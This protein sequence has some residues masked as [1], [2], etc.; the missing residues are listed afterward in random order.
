VEGIGCHHCR[1]FSLYITLY[2]LV[3]H[4]GHGRRILTDFSQLDSQWLCWGNWWL[5][6]SYSSAMLDRSWLCEFFFFGHYQR[7]GI[8][9]QACCDASSQFTTMS[10]NSPGGMNDSVAFLGWGLFLHHLCH[11]P[12]CNYMIGD[13]AYCLCCFILT[14][15]MKQQLLNRT[16]HDSYNFF[17]SQLRIWIELQLGNDNYL[18]CS[19]NNYLARRWQLFDLIIW[20]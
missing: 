13:L 11:L 1:T 12:L 16:D 4:W 19:N 17:L 7:Y 10:I 5:A 14:P 15:F 20:K 9:V 2:R 18:A 3:H 6:L 8:N